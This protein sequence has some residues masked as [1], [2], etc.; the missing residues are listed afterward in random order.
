MFS[1]T[2][3]R[4][5]FIPTNNRL[6]PKHINAPKVIPGSLKKYI[7]SFDGKQSYFEMTTGVIYYRYDCYEK[8]S[9][10]GFDYLH[11]SLILTN[12][13]NELPYNEFDNECKY[14]ISLQLLDYKL[15]VQKNSLS[16]FSETIRTFNDKL[17]NVYYKYGKLEF[18]D[19]I[20]L[21]LESQQELI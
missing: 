8:S 17:R 12:F 21:S 19:E 5:D 13:S 1:K 2:F 15:A 9:P 7:T 6:E 20:I 4:D 14:F 10:Y 18:Y 11:K 16:K 3:F